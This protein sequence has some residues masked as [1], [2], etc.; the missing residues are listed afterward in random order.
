M[1][2]TFFILLMAMHVQLVFGQETPGQDE[3]WQ[4][5][6]FNSPDVALPLLID[7]AARN[8]A[9]VEVLEASNQIAQ[10]QLSLEK[11]EL[12]RGVRLHSAYSYGSMVN[13]FDREA[14]NNLNAFSQDARSMYT[15]GV[16]IGYSLEQLFGGRRLRVHQREMQLKQVEAQRRIGERDLRK[17]IIALYQELKLAR[18]VLEHSQEAMQS[19]NVSKN[20]AERQFRSGQIK[21]DEQMAV[22]ELYSNAFLA[23]E[24]A[25]S[26]YQT[27]L[28]YLEEA[29]GMTIEN[30]M[31]RK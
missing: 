3:N 10:D 25:K 29:I 5:V 19:A 2:K 31:S 14:L 4:E 26:K 18:K 17:E 15:V 11:K 20:L 27:A 21:V 22:N 9:E 6:F 12:L 13:V 24:Q 23:H 7:A 16:S 28:L 1:R 8:S 30:L